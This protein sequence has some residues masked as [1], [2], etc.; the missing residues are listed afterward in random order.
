MRRE[1]IDDQAPLFVTSSDPKVM[2]VSGVDGKDEL[3]KSSTAQLKI[4][5]VNGSGAV[6][7]KAAEL[8]IRYGSNEGVIIAA[9]SV[10]VFTKLDVILTP[11]LVT[12]RDDGGTA[13]PLPWT[14]MR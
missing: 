2:T 13:L 6:D 12:I 14:L 8:E 5:G 9:M 1:R 7:P 4:N 3:P 11:H 10:W